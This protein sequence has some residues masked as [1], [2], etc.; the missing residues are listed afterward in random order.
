LSIASS[1][2]SQG[3][4]RILIVSHEVRF[5]IS[6]KKVLDKDCADLICGGRLASPN[7]AKPRP[8]TPTTNAAKCLHLQVLIYSELPRNYTTFE[9]W[10]DDVEDD[11]SSAGRHNQE[12]SES[13]KET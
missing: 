2:R 8:A 9:A 12:T 1:R 5:S 6:R 3:K 10:E 4:F 11:E 13:G 7:G